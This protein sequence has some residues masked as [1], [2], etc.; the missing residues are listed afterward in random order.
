ML[1]TYYATIGQG[2]R[3]YEAT[4]GT[5][6]GDGIMA[7]LNDPV[8]CDD[9]PRKAVEMALSLAPSMGTLVDSWKRKG[10]QLGY[11]VG[12]AY[13]YATLGTI[14]FEGRYDYT[15]LGSV[16][17]LAARLCGEA[18]AG[19]L[20]VDQRT[21]DAVWDTIMANT[22]EVKLKGLSS[23]VNAFEVLGLR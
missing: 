18:G 20:L 6:S 11:G 1:D 12:I 9:P 8:P 16:V 2:L 17:N 4:V 3:N 14:G 13:G 22:R 7:Y 5:F 23:P 10:F 21:H 15:A 19:E